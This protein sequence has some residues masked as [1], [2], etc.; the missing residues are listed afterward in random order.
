MRRLLRFL[1]LSVGALIGTVL[2]LVVVVILWPGVLL[3]DRTLGW[4]GGF[5]R[6]HGIVDVRWSERHLHAR[7]ESFWDKRIELELSDPCF[8]ERGSVHVCFEHLK[9]EATAT[10]KKFPPI[11]TRVGP[12]EGRAGELVIPASTERAGTAPNRP[13]RDE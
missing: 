11:L 2:A 1:L 8:D 13:K 9:V 4:T 7:S 10:L 12:I 6:K 3:N 5:L